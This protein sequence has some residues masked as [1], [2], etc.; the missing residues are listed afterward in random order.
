[1]DVTVKKQKVD[2]V[3]KVIKIFN[4]KNGMKALLVSLSLFMF[5]YCS[6]TQ[7]IDPQKKMLTNTD[8]L[9]KSKRQKTGAWILLGS[10]AALTTTG[11]LVGS[12]NAA[13]EILTGNSKG[14]DAAVII[15]V[16][17]MVCMVSSIPLF[18]A[19]GKNKRKATNTSVSLKFEDRPFLQQYSLNKKQFPAL[20]LKIRL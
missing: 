3:K 1:M 9:K 18:I 8:Y 4:K 14:F 5:I 13:E 17:G 10:G 2:A 15:W 19:A 7:Q 12:D 16:S 6:Y 11:I 20:S